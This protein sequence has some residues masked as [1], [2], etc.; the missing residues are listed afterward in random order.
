MYI[1][2]VQLASRFWAAIGK[3]A[4]LSAIRLH[5]ATA[6]S[7]LD[8]PVMFLPDIDKALHAI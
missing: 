5:A 2:N 3:A 8:L 6:Y 1:A 4:A 7:L